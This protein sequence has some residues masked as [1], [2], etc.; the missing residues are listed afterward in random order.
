MIL[1]KLAKRIQNDLYFADEILKYIM[2]LYYIEF[3][4]LYSTSKNYARVEHDLKFGFGIKQGL[5]LNECYKKCSAIVKPLAELY[6]ITLESTNPLYLVS[7][8]SQNERK[9]EKIEDKTVLKS[10][11]GKTKKEEK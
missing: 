2:K 9:I 5:N 6:D 10:Y 11:K 3:P 7:G 1:Q 4:R 8:I